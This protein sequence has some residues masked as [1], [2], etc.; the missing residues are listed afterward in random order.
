[1]EICFELGTNNEL[2]STNNEHVLCAR[3]YSKHSAYLI[4]PS[5]R[6]SCSDANYEIQKRLKSLL[7][8][9]QLERDG[10]SF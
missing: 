10:S 3:H 7:Q 6:P 1:M 9:A 5:P 2:A 4:S 8:G